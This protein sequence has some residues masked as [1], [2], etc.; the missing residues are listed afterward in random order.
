MI[1]YHYTHSH[2][3]ATTG[4]FTCVPEQD[5][6]LD[7]ILEYLVLCPL[8]S[9]MRRYALQKISELAPEKIM[10]YFAPWQNDLPPSLQALWQEIQIVF[11]SLQAKLKQFTIHLDNPNTKLQKVANGSNALA[12]QDLQNQSPLIY[13]RCQNISENHKIWVELFRL[14]IQEHKKLPSLEQNSKTSP[15]LQKDTQ[16]FLAELP[17]K[18]IVA[19]FAEPFQVSLPQVISTMQ[20]ENLLKDESPSSASTVA[21]AEDRLQRADII[22]GQEMRHTASLS[23]IAL[24]RPWKVRFQVQE[25][26]NHIQLQGQ[27]TTYGRGLCLD[28]ARASCLMEMVERASVYLS[29]SN[30]EITERLQHTPVIKSKRSE[31]LNQ[32]KKALDPNNFPLEAPY[33]DALLSWLTGHTC[34]LEEIYIPVQMAG[35]FSNLDEIDLFE[36]M[37]STGIATGNS[38]EQA[39]IAALLEIIERDAEA[40]TPFDKSSCFTLTSSDQFISKLLEAYKSYGINV[41]FQDLTGAL[42]VPVFQCFVMNTKGVISRGYG[43]GLS[44][45]KAIVSALTETPF[46]FPAEPSGPMLRNLPVRHLEDLPDYSLP[47]LS[48]NLKALENLFLANKRIP[49]YAVLTRK[50]LQ[51]PVVRAF[52]EGMELTAESDE[53]SHL[54]LRLWLNYQ[55]GESVL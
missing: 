30:G 14:N 5:L 51:F 4:Y 6:S 46:A 41:Q 22:A 9:F 53:L 50:D 47:T 24:L 45:R 49:A 23:P 1:S 35:L 13:L 54:P 15:Y 11:P 21:L 2:T 36:A 29:V 27:G 28:D 44:S 10:E 32:G 3:K 12:E 7:A 31:L 8:D 16:W 55:K 33:N 18:A 20:K 26:R 39:K 37:G 25:G 40:T 34:L 17:E 19:C 38:L 48:Q 52:V 42:G 43:A